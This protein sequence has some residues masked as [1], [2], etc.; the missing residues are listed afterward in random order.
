MTWRTLLA[1]LEAAGL[2]PLG[3]DAGALH[4]ALADPAVNPPPVPW[5]VRVMVGI[6]A[7]IAGCFLVGSTLACLGLLLGGED[8]TVMSAVGLVL[9]VMGV[10]LRLGV[11]GVFAGQLA[12]SVGAAGQLLLGGGLSESLGVTAHSLVWVGLST[13]LVLLH[14]DP[15]QRF[16]STVVGLSALGV[17]FDRVAPW[18][19]GDLLL[20]VVTA[21]LLVTTYVPETALSSRTSAIRPPLR[22]GLVVSLLLASLGGEWIDVARDVG[23]LEVVPGFRLA[24]FVLAAGLL[25][26][27]ARALRPYG[28]GL[29]S[30][31]GALA[32]VTTLTLGALGQGR[33]GLL[34]A[35][36]GMVVSFA[37]HDK[38][39]VGLSTVFLVVFGVHFYYDLVL[40]LW[41]KSGVLVGSGLV[42]LAVRAWLHHRHLLGG[43]PGRGE[44]GRADVVEAT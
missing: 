16:A 30:E 4:A 6:G 17:L 12:L 24:P 15:V 40:T 34:A 2:L 7:W 11:P 21:G 18:F 3:P 32:V 8:T 44:P 27:I 31:P 29:A 9:L 14:P 33:P 38:V 43:G 10:G 37:A 25:V 22:L 41:V 39:A 36:L 42:L 1:R 20:A 26:A 35:L 28:V 5:M 13:A 19:S 23:G